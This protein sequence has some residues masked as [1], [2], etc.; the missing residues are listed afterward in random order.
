MSAVG[1]EARKFSYESVQKLD[2]NLI[3]AYTSCA[4]FILKNAQDFCNRECVKI[5]GEKSSWGEMSNS[6]VLLEYIQGLIDPSKDE[7]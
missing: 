3:E 5:G 4:N 1:L 7:V 2:P 6:S